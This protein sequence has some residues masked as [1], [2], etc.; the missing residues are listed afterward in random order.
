M[1]RDFGCCAKLEVEV[2]VMVNTKAF[3]ECCGFAV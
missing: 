3:L 2:K 1:S